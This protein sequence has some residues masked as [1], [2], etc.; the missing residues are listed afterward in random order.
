MKALLEL[1]DAA[2]TPLLAILCWQVYQIM[3]NHLPHLHAE[4]RDVGERVSKLEGKLD[5]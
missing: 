5:E 4:V 2:S 1:V 3:T